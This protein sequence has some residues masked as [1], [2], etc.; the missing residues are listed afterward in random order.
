[1]WEAQSSMAKDILRPFVLHVPHASTA[2]PG[3]LRDRFLLS[4][5]VLD[6][7]LLLMTDR[8]TDELFDLSPNDTVQFP[9]SRL[10]VDPERF[11]EDA[12]EPMASVGMGEMGAVYTRTHDG[13]QLKRVHGEEERL[14]LLERFYWPHHRALEA[15]VT[16]RLDKF[17][18]CLV[19]DCH[20]FHP[21]PLPHEPDQD[22]DRP[23]IDLGT[24]PI[25]TPKLLASVA[26]RLFA[27]AG[28]S[29][30]FNQPFSGAMVP[31]SRYRKDSRVAAL[32]I[33][34][35]RDLYMDTQT[36]ARSPQFAAFR[37]RLQSILG[38]VVTAWEA[39]ELRG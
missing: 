20:S 30:A 10:V 27:D 14:S 18:R 19:L 9:I 8:Y 5:A 33:E 31:A 29:V 22:P 37:T 35:R 28:L 17:G 4:P 12:D 23:E 16:Q 7:E 25:H 38:Q 24:D 2:I 3:G 36:G 26:E 11:P 21:A 13:A 15:A 6:R 32:M 34:V 1:M 39:N